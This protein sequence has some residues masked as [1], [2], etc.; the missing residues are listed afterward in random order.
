MGAAAWTEELS[1]AP[2]RDHR[3]GDLESEANSEICTSIKT[4]AQSYNLVTGGI[5]ISSPLRLKIYRSF[6][7]CLRSERLASYSQKLIVQR[8]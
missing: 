8:G 1:Q 3:R 5:T 4:Q 2:R 6:R 7:T